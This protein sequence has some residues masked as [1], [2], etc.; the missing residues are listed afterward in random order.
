MLISQALEQMVQEFDDARRTIARFILANERRIPEMTTAQVADETGTSKPTLVRVVKQLGFSGWRDF[1]RAWT[2]ELARRDEHA[3]DVDHNVPFTPDASVREIIDSIT[4]VRTEAAWQTAQMLDERDLERAVNLMLKARRVLLMGC[5]TNASLLRIFQYQLMQIGILAEQRSHDEEKTIISFMGPEDVVLMVSYTGEGC[6][7]SPM[8]HI[9][10]LEAAGCPI[11]AVTG[12]GDNYLRDHATV[13]LSILS[14]ENLYRK[15][16]TFSTL[17]STELVLN[18]L[19]GAIFAH[20]YERNYRIKTERAHVV[21]QNR[22]PSP[23][24]G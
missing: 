14:R 5:T 13:A 3:T 12:E 24:E 21:E 22:L 11:I 8:C 4:R 1:S 19:Y 18:V 7:R 10:A 23:C 9:P 15:M 17:E 6:A 2:R 16:G 20:D